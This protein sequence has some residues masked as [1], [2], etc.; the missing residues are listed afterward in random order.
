MLAAL[1]NNTAITQERDR[2]L[3]Y[4][5][6]LKRKNGIIA[7]AGPFLKMVS[8]TKTATFDYDKRERYIS[9]STVYDSKPYTQTTLP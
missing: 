2:I 8:S 1:K 3:S 7:D 5:E 4:R 6:C 9:K